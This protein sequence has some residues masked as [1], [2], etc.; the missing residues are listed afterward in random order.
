LLNLSPIEK[1]KSPSANIIEVNFTVLANFKFDVKKIAV[2]GINVK[3]VKY[4]SSK[5][6]N[7]TLL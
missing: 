2:N 7:K 4:G 5:T 1:I 6:Q 3:N